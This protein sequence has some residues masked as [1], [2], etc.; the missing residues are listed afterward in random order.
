MY[1]DPKRVRDNRHTLRLDDYEEDVIRAV[2]NYQ[3]EQFSTMLRQMAVREAVRCLEELGGDS[4][5]QRAA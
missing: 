1:P 5:R 3:G 4:L 2:A